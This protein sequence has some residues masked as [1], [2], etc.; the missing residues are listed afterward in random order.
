[1]KVKQ[2]IKKLSGLDPEADVVVAESTFKVFAVRYVHPGT[3]LKKEKF[4]VLKDWIESGDQKYLTTVYGQDVS[5]MK[6]NAVM[7]TSW[8]GKFGDD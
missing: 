3:Y 2:L 8:S 4:F 6:P 5:T 7:L 1:M